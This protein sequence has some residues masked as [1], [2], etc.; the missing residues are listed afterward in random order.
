M[1]FYS[2]KHV[3]SVLKSLGLCPLKGK[4]EGHEFWGNVSGRTCRPRLH[5]REMALAHVYSLGDELET[6]GICS[7]K[8][9]I[10]AVKG[11]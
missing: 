9:F 6:Q 7:R 5:T 11:R 1:P 10:Q 2:T 8:A 3:R 4:A